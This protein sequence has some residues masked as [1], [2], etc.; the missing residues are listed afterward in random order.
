MATIKK[1]I[2][3]ANFNETNSNSVN[4][5]G[6]VPSLNKTKE[7]MIKELNVKVSNAQERDALIEQLKQMEFKKPLPKSIKDLVNQEGYALD[8]LGKLYHVDETNNRFDTLFVDQTTA[9]SARAM[10]RLSQLMH[11]YNDGWKPDWND[12]DQKKYTIDRYNGGVVT[13][14]VWRAYQYLAFKD[15]QIRDLFKDRFDTLIRE[16]FELPPIK[17]QF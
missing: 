10:A 7:P 8:P 4:Y 6:N 5:V 3:Y 13:D 1:T 12:G 2:V 14:T 16:Y 11:V 15:A 17:E 9:K